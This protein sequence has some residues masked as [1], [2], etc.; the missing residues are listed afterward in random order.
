MNLKNILTTNTPA[1]I[2]DLI[3]YN[4]D[5]LVANGYGAPG[6]I[7]AAGAVGTD[8]VQGVQG[9]TG[10][11]GGIGNTGSAGSVANIEWTNDY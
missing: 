8:G 5:Q 1:E 10:S 11:T 7:G 6:A 3:N 4:F 2:I 9:N